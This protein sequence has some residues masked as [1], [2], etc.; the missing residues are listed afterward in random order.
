M[1]NILAHVVHNEETIAD[2]LLHPLTGLDHIASMVFVAASIVPLFVA[3][4]GRRAATTAGTVT[5]VRST[6]F[7]AG[8]AALL[9][10]SIIALVAI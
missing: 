9:V 8:S 3:L 5:R 1:M 10:A 6:T 2:K 4:R 7:V